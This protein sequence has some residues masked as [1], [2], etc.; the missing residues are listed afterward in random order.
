MN[1]DFLD[2]TIPGCKNFKWSE[3]L[4]LNQWNIHVVPTLDDLYNIEAIAKKAQ[5]IR[6]FLDRPMMITSWYRPQHYNTLIGGA[7]SSWHRTGGAIDFRCFN[8]S[9][10]AV[11]ETLEPKLEEFGLRMENLPGS[12]WVH[13][14]NK[15]PKNGNRFFIP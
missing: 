11:R 8:F 3:A 7:P 10:D 4:Y 1:I 2:K 15:D 9:A 6:D 5:L 14:D 12:N 13:I